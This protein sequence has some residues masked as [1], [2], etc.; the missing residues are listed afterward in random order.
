MIYWLIAFL[1]LALMARALGH[2]RAAEGFSGAA[3][4]MAGLTILFFLCVA[5]YL[6]W[7]VLNLRG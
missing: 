6:G 3:R 1:A 5:L 2:D 7:L 4:F